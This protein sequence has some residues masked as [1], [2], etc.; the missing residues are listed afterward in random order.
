MPINLGTS[1]VRTLLYRGTLL[2]GDGD[3]EASVFAYRAPRRPSPERL[4]TS[5]TANLHLWL[6]NFSMIYG[7]RDLHHT[8]PANVHLSPTKQKGSP[9]TLSERGHFFLIFLFFLSNHCTLYRTVNGLFSFWKIN[10]YLM[11]P[12]TFMQAS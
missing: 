11:L 2:G 3:A 9:Q 4:C 6:P 1:C 5:R 8:S 7:A 12:F 10:H